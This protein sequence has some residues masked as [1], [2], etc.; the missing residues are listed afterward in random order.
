[1]EYY[2]S[3]TIGDTFDNTLQK[4][5][6]ALKVEGFGV[7]TEIDLK[8]TLKKKLDVYFYNYTILGACNP[9]FAYKALLAEDK[10]GTMLPCNVI[11][12]EKIKGQV[13][14]SAVDPAASMQAVDNVALKEIAKEIRDRL[15]R[16]ID[17][18]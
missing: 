14:V 4:V 8:T 12:Q 15:K 6:E 2:F 5:T 16:V 1:M 13:E 10:I 18:L 17:N 3:K 11:V 7:L 9:S